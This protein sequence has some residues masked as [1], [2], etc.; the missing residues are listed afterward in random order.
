MSACQHE[1]LHIKFPKKSAFNLPIL[2]EILVFGEAFFAFRVLISFIT[3]LKLVSQK[4]KLA[5]K[6]L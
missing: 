4:V 5:S 1:F 2:V 6:P 3:S